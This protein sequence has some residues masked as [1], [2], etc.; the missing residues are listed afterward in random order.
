[1]IYESRAE[2]HYCTSVMIRINVLLMLKEPSEGFWWY[3]IK[4]VCNTVKLKCIIPLLKQARKL[5]SSG[6]SCYLV[7]NAGT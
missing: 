5:I 1:M 3:R 6:V 7:G 4:A 2:I